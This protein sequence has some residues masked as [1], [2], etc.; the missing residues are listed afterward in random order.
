MKS[1]LLLAVTQLAAERSLPADVVLTAVQDALT[2]AYKRDSGGEDVIV[3]LD[4]DTG[5]VA[6]RTVRKVVEEVEDS[7]A[8]WTIQEAKKVSPDAKIGDQITTGHIESNPG[9]IAAQTAKQLV[10]QRL[11]DAERELVFDE[12]VGKEGEVISAT[13]QRIDSRFLTLDLGR[14]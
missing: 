13:V 10:M 8:E 1:D 2:M 9:R 4:P 14:A 5:D 6:A 7:E 3:T 11:R 12:F